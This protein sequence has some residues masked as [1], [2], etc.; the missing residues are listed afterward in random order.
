MCV[1]FHPG[2]VRTEMGGEGADISVEESVQGMVQVLD[3]LQA[4]DNG[5][6]FNYDGQRLAW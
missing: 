6:F 4:K 1:S 2:W 5:S 3:Q